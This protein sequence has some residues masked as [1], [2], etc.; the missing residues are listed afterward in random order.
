MFEFLQR[1]TVREKAALIIVIPFFIIALIYSLVIVPVWEQKTRFNS[2]AQRKKVELVAFRELAAQFRDLEN[3]IS[4]LETNMKNRAGSFSI[5]GMLEREARELGIQDRIASM[6]P[7]NSQLD[8][9]IRESSVE[10]RFEK[11][12]LNRTVEFLKKI[13]GSKDLVVIKRLRMKSRFDDPQ[14]LDVTLLASTLDVQ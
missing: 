12:D 5:L 1:L 8:Q 2:M 14:L 4:G 7:M 9:K 11:L 13:E 10:I 3:S 6:K